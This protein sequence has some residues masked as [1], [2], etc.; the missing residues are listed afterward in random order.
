MLI[1][2]FARRRHVELTTDEIYDHFRASG[3]R[4]FRAGQR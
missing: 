1:C 4:S 2:E 3:L